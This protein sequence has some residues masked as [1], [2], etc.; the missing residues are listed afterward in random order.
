MTP[1]AVVRLERLALVAGLALMVLAVGALD[2]RAGLLLAG[3]LLVLSALD[4]PRRHP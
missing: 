2:W 4:I 3:L 1:G